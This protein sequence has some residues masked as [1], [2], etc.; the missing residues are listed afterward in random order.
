MNKD[1]VDIYPLQYSK[2]FVNVLEDNI[3][4]RGALTKLVSDRAQVEVSGRALEILRIYAISSWQS[5]PHQ[6]HQNY[7]ERKIQHLKQMANTA[8]DRTGAPPTVW[9]LCLMYVAYV[10]NHSLNDN[11]KNV[12]LTALLGVT[13][14]TSVLLRYHFWQQV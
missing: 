13:V 6:H 7:A 5:E 1:V 8:M 4:F 9:L 14:D 3:R 11:I 10:L 2:Q 12:P